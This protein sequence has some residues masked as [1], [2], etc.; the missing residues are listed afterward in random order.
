MPGFRNTNSTGPGFAAPVARRDKRVRRILTSSYLVFLVT[1]FDAARAR[2]S[3][4]GGLRDEDV[5]SIGKSKRRR[6]DCR[7]GGGPHVRWDGG[8]A[9]SQ[10]V[11][12]GELR[13][14]PGSGLG[15]RCG[16][17]GAASAGR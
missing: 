14:A 15:E 2:H 11:P 13:D 12:V 17:R 1:A 4:Y 8:S 5:Y 10:P 6:D 7:C 16:G 3:P 9:A